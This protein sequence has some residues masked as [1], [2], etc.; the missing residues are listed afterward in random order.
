MFRT[1]A[2]TVMRIIRDDG[3]GRH[4][5]RQ[6]RS[7]RRTSLTHAAERQSVQSVQ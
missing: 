2:T 6:V 7:F 3:G 5:K 1:N 4:T